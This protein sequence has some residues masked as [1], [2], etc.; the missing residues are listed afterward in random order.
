[1]EDTAVK[2]SAGETE[3]LVTEE[4]VVNM[5]PQHPSTH[6]VLRFVLK[7]DG[8]VIKELTPV[9]GY[10][11]RGMEKIAENRTYHQ[12]IPFT[13]RLDYVASMSNNWA[14]VGAVEKILEIHIPERAEYIR[15]IMSE[16]NR[17]GSHLIWF[18]TFGL[19]LGAITPFL[20]S[21]GREREQ[22]LDLFE[23]V[24]GQRLT[25]N[26][27]RIGGVSQDLPPG[28]VSAARSFVDYFLPKVD[29]Y[30]A[31][32]STNGIFLVRTKGIGILDARTAIDWGATG[33]VLRGS[34]VKW[35]LR[36][37]DPYSVYPRFEFDVPTGSVGDVY[38]RY[39]VRM[40]E[41][42]QSAR[43]LKQALE[44][45][46]E[47]EIIGTVPKVIRPPAG[48]AYFRIESPRGE[49]GFFVVS[50]GTT[51]PYRLKIRSGAFHNLSVVPL[52]APGFKVAD[53]VA[54]TGSVDPVAG[55]IDR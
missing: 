28:F 55:E 51:K 30:D 23:S 40:Q 43:I 31:L 17:I 4:F 5:G 34:G 27:L 33:P 16:L 3:G 48:E 13:D 45:L 26:Y 46:P 54:I 8:E 41:M 42:R 1:M 35:D 29:E 24:C 50:D 52:L 44:S 6:G 2:S 15:V 20:Y 18:G 14:Y 36:K 37:N 11:H 12:F 21:F 32:L 22:I 39:Q 47:G 10:L 19:D 7:L 38:D 53:L 9:V 49:L 25:Y